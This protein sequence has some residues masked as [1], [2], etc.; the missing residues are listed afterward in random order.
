MFKHRTPQLIAILGLMFASATQ[1]S[2]IAMSAYTYG[3]PEGVSVSVPTYSGG[4]GAFN[5]TL[6]ANPLTVYCIDLVQYF[7]WNS[8]FA[9]TPTSATVQFG[10]SKALA[11]GQLYTQNFASVS[12]AKQS[13]AFQLAI[14]EIISE[15]GSGYSL[16]SGSFQGSSSDPSVALL[17]G[18]WLSGLSGAGNG[19]TLTA[20]VSSTKQDQLGASPVPVPGAAAL[21]LSGF[22]LLSAVARRRKSVV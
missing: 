17:A 2:T 22:G 10:A 6:D 3:G 7:N 21:M 14:W 1:A 13:A 20:Y 9:V 8:A 15:T 5:A 19:Y 12:N 4:A 11:L 18:T 16:T